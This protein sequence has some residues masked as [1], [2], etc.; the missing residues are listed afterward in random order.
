MK[1]VTDLVDYHKQKGYFPTTAKAISDYTS[2][3]QEIVNALR[4]GEEISYIYTTLSLIERGNSSPLYNGSIAVTNER[5]IL[6][7][8]IRTGI[9]MNK[10]SY[11]VSTYEV[12]SITSLNLDKR[13]GMVAEIKIETISHDDIGV[14]VGGIN[15]PDGNVILNELS[16]AINAAKNKNQSS[17]TPAISTADELKKFK[18]LLDMGIISQE[19]FDAKKKQLLGL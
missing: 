1:T 19:E 11:T 12:S 6:G 17:T 3:F 18:E 2:I 10:I 9:F 5:I 14:T 15:S 16:S 7:G 4:N 8:Q 13:P